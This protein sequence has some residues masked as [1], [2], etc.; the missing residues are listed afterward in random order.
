MSISFRAACMR[1]PFVSSLSFLP[2]SPPL[3]ALPKSQRRLVGV[4]RLRSSSPALA[5]VVFISI[6]TKFER[7]CRPHTDRGI[8]RLAGG[9]FPRPPG[10]SKELHVCGLTG[11]VAYLALLL[12]VVQALLR[13]SANEITGVPSRAKEGSS[14]KSVTR[15]GLPVVEASGELESESRSYI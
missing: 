7:F 12:V 4:S 15:G 11:W 10:S 14:K 8:Q 6:F 9:D 5:T 1:R 3:E 13:F 2:S